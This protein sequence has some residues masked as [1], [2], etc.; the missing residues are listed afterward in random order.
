LDGAHTNVSFVAVLNLITITIREDGVPLFSDVGI[1]I[2]M[3]DPF[4]DVHSYTCSDG[5][6]NYWPDGGNG[7]Y[8]I[9]PIK[10]GY[11]FDPKFESVYWDNSQGI[12]VNFEAYSD[13]TPIETFTYSWITSDLD[14]HDGEM[15]RDGMLARGYTELGHS[16]PASNTAV[17]GFFENPGVGI[18]LHTGHGSDNSIAMDVGSDITTS[19]F[20]NGGIQA[21]YIAILTCLTLSGSGWIDKMGPSSMGLMGYTQVT[22]DYEDE[23]VVQQFLDNMG[24]DHTMAWTWYQANLGTAEA[25]AWRIFYRENSGVSDYRPSNVPSKALPA[26]DV[27]VINKTVSVVSN[28]LDDS[29]KFGD[30]FVALESNHYAITG[31]TKQV[32][33][34]F[35]IQHEFLAKTSITETEAMAIASEYLGESLPKDAVLEYALP[36][37]SNGETIAYAIRYNR[38]LNGLPI[39]S[40]SARNHIELMVNDGEVAY[41]STLWPEITTTTIDQ[42]SALDNLLSV[43]EA[44]ELAAADM[45]TII[46]NPVTIVDVKVVYANTE[47]EIIPAYAL[48]TETGDEI[49]IDAA[50]GK[51][52]R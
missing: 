43:N 17:R 4:G 25:D 45:D 14:P 44:V 32:A 35:R 51:V 18:H 6:C 13:G 40:N 5:N 41:S 23:T 27:Q 9:T 48:I 38:T 15:F 42:P 47:T 39:Q 24:D 50:T 26:D 3:P 33:Q 11:S 7:T 29:L 2:I 1:Y 31:S 21:Q 28:L 10:S 19:T 36:I 8:T 34:D 49:V 20:S 16:I 12:N 37:T 46:K 22:S 52:V 30:D